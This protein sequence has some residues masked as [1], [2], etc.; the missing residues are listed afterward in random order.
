MA[1]APSDARES[2]LKQTRNYAPRSRVV[3]RGRTQGQMRSLGKFPTSSFHKLSLGGFKYAD[4]SFKEQFIPPAMEKKAEEWWAGPEGLQ[5]SWWERS[6]SC[7][8][9]LLPALQPPSLPVHPSI[10]PVGGPA[11]WRD[12]HHHFCSHVPTDQDTNVQEHM[13]ISHSFL[14]D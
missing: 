2:G 12:V 13:N 4:Y 3:S 11:C 8:S 10:P 5:P 6:P 14:R 7:S 9:A 1:P